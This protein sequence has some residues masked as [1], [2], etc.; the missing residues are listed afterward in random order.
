MKTIFCDHFEKRIGFYI[1]LIYEKALLVNSACKWLNSC[2][3]LLVFAD[4]WQSAS[5]S[6]EIF[7]IQRTYEKRQERQVKANKRETR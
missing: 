1:D 3:K 5:R 6:K 2:Q 4:Q 7:Q